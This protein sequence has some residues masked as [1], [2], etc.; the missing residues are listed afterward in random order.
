MRKR[1]P[2]GSNWKNIRL[3]LAKMPAFPDG[4]ASRAYMLHVPLREDGTIDEQALLE[5]PA[6]AGFRRFWPNEPDRSGRL[7]RA[8]SGWALSLS[9]TDG[10]VLLPIEAGRL[11]PGDH[12]TI[13]KRAG[14]NWR[15]RVV[16]LP[17][18]GSSQS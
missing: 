17:P 7:V 9:T 18:A 14:G 11:L 10:E 3:E 5:N 4:S 6:F 2:S 15:F 12:V 1:G 13:D 8:G 16:D